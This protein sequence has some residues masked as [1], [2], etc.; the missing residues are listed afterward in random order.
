MAT[1]L[2]SRSAVSTWL[3]STHN[4]LFLEQ[5]KQ[6]F[7]DPS[8]PVPVDNLPGGSGT[9]D[10]MGGEQPPGNGLAPL[11]GVGFGQFDQVQGDLCRHRGR[12]GIAWP[13]DRDDPKPQPQPG[14]AL[15]PTRALA[16]CHPTGAGQRPLPGNRGQGAATDRLRSW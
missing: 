6:L 5:P 10:G 2:S 11:W 4:S 14:L 12:A 8:G 15:G 1:S 3:S 7:D 16:Q 13:G 9:G